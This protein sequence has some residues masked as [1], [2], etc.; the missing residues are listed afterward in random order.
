MGGKKP[1]REEFPTTKPLL[2]A[3]ITSVV[4]TTPTA[5]QE[6][7]NRFYKDLSL[8]EYRSEAAVRCKRRFETSGQRLFT[9]LRHDGVPQN[10]NNPEHGI[11]A[12]ARARELF[13]GTPTSK[14]IS[15]YLVLFSVCYRHVGTNGL[16]FWISCARPKATRRTCMLRRSRT[17]PYYR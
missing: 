3:T 13:Q 5:A 17:A 6:P 7:V 1:A 16:I 10:N 2:V 9:F 4:A 12:Y 8:R 14:A 11:K 15:E